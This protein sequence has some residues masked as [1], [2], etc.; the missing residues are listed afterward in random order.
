MP[1][2]PYNPSSE[3]PNR[4]TICWPGGVNM[5]KISVDVQAFDEK[6]R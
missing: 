2:P 1:T 3:R 4:G 5:E 6:T